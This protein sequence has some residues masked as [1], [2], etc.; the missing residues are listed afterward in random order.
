MPGAARAGVAFLL[1]LGLMVGALLLAAPAADGDPTVDVIVQLCLAG[2]VA[3]G[4]VVLLTPAGPDL[5]AA[6]RGWLVVALVGAFLATGAALVLS[7]S[8]FPPL[9][10]AL[11]Q[12]FRAASVTKYAHTVDLVD[13]A[14]RDL[15]AF[16]P[17]LFFWV[18]GRAAAWLGVEPYEALKTGVLLSALVA[19]I[20]SFALWRRVTRDVMVALA[21]AVGALAFQDWYEPYAWLAVVAFVPWWLRFVLQVGAPAPARPATIVGASLVGA[22]I[23]CTYHY[24]FFVGR[25]AAR[26]WRWPSAARRRGR[27]WCWGPGAAGDRAGARGHRGRERGLL[28]AAAGLDPDHARRPLDADPVPRCDPSVD[29]PMPFLEFDLV[30]WLTLIGLGYL[31]LAM[32]RSE[33]AA[34]LGL[35]AR[36]RLRVVPPRR[37][38][39]SSST[40]RCSTCARRCWSRWCSSRAPRSPSSTPGVQWRGRARWSP[41]TAP[42][43]CAARSWWARSSSCSRWAW[44]RSRR[45]R[46]SASSGPPPSPSPC[47]TPSSARRAAMRTAPWCS[48][49]ARSFRN[50]CRCTCSTCGTRTTATP[51][52]SS[53]GAPPSSTASRASATPTCSRR[54]CA[55]T[56]TTGSTRS[57]SVPSGGS[58][59]YT[60]FDDAFPRGVSRRTITFTTEQFDA[61]W[62]SRRGS[63]ALAVYVPRDADPLDALDDD[64]LRALRRA[65][66]GDL[67][68][69]SP[70]SR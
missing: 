46:T 15:P 25:G 49:T 13:F 53:A 52:P 51:R 44:T 5:T 34:A 37:R 24:F 56:G 27:A 9:G 63:A 19:P 70:A 1:A 6:T 18:L 66:R 2:A 10:V 57:R 14:Y 64:Q 23:L 69:V 42:P 62:F 29:V 4:L 22:A 60:F 28:A 59:P 61:E 47:S 8:D 43:R 11:D 45:S 67:E 12:G 58:L 55:T 40:S 17:P 35:T 41:A 68:G 30:G 48:P 65:F 21:V 26:G 38:R 32:F 16:Y 36:G 39:A 20:V 7:G 31:A 3:A 33:L 50:T 54:R